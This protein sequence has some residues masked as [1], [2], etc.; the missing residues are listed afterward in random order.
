MATVT[1][2]IVV[3]LGVGLFCALATCIYSIASFMGSIAGIG[4]SH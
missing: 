1:K 4:L 3:L 2:L